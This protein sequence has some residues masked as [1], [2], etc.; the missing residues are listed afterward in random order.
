VAKEEKLKTLKT[1]LEKVPHEVALAKKLHAEGSEGRPDVWVMTGKTAALAA[2]LS[3]FIGVG[4]KGGQTISLIFTGHEGEAGKAAFDRALAALKTGL[5]EGYRI[6]EQ[7]YDA[8]KG[9]MTFKISAP[10]GQK[11]DE[12]L[13]KKL[14]ESLKEAIKTEK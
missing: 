10:E 8:D 12:T 2:K 5:P 7:D 3:T 4:D 6:T 9:V 14:V 13:I 11:T 1:K